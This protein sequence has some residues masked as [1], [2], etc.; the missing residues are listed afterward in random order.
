MEY[1]EGF[2]VIVLVIR[3]VV[4]I[5]GSSI[6]KRK[7][8]SALSGFL[9]G[10]LLGILGV[11]ICYLHSDRT[12]TAYEKA[13]RRDNLKRMIAEGSISKAE[14]DRATMEIDHTPTKEI[15]GM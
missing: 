2:A 7:G 12:M 5:W 4:A 9:Y 14:Y 3:L 8:R 6:M 10:V 1:K 13:H 11:I 15:W